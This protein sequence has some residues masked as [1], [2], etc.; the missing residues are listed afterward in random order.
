[1]DIRSDLLS[2]LSPAPISPAFTNIP[3]QIDDPSS[4]LEQFEEWAVERLRLLR[5]VEKHNMGGKVGDSVLFVLFDH[6]LPDQV[7]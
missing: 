7:F 5:T 3:V 2:H 4:S 6:R 1:M